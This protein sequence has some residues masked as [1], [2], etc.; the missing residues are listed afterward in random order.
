M[1]QWDFT[2]GFVALSAKVSSTK[3]VVTVVISRSTQLTPNN[4]NTC[5]TNLC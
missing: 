2:L 4:V 5:N 3:F 1:L